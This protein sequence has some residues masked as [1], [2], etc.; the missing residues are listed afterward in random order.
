MSELQ[1]LPTN[2]AHGQQSIWHGIGVEQFRAK[3]ARLK[4]INKVPAPEVTHSRSVSAATSA[5]DRCYV[6]PFETERSLADDF[7]I[8]ASSKKDAKAVSAA[9]IQESPNGDTLTIRLAA[10]DSVP[11]SVISMFNS[12][13]T[14]LRECAEQSQ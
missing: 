4:Q 2:T 5:Q 13:F 3:I 11:S 9:T 14:M 12:I 10:N 7:A 6:L 1:L 8:L